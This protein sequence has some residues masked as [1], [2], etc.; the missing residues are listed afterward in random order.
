MF[1]QAKKQPAKEAPKE[2]S[3]RERIE[4]IRAECE[5]FIDAR[6]E[7]LRAVAPGIPTP[8]LRQQIVAHGWGQCP[9]RAVLNFKEN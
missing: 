4:A 7:E 9:C 8:V 5:S 3:L 1:K 6:A 2:L